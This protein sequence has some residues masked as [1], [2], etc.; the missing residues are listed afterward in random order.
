MFERYSIIEGNLKIARLWGANWE[1]SGERRIDLII[2]GL[3]LEYAFF[4]ELSFLEK[5]WLWPAKRKSVI[6]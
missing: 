2:V 5:M 4:G 6:V 1:F 3:S